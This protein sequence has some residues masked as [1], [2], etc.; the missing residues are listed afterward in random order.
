MMN[1]GHS[2]DETYL[3]NT[4]ATIRYPFSQP[5]VVASHEQRE[6]KLF[7]LPE[8]NPARNPV[9]PSG[10]QQ[11]FHLSYYSSRSLTAHRYT[12]LFAFHDGH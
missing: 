1:V 11:R 3:A 5:L 12:Y 8:E 6:A 7:P 9:C 10:I 4:V 2:V